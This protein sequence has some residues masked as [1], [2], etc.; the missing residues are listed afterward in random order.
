MGLICVLPMLEVVHNL[1]KLAQNKDKFICDYVVATKLCQAY[2]YTMY[3]LHGYLEH[4]Y[5]HFK[6]F[7]DLLQSTNVTIPIMWWTKPQTQVEYVI[8]QFIQLLYMLH[9][10]DK[11]IINVSMVVKDDWTSTCQSVKE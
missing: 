8:F 4:S 9:K 5:D 10:I 11:S 3:V 2:L 6:N 1:N 7:L